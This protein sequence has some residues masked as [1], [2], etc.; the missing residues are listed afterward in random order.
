MPQSGGTLHLAAPYG[1]A[2]K[3]LDPHATYTS[4]DMV[5]SKAFH[6]S[7]YTWESEKNAPALDLARL[8]KISEDGKTFTYELFDNIYFHNGR[9]LTTDDV[10]WS[11]TRIMDPTKGYPGRYKSEHWLARRNMRRVKPRKSAASKIDDRTFSLTFKDLVDP[12]TQ[13]FE[14]IT[15]ILPREEVESGNFLSHPVGLGPF[16]FESHVEGSK[17][18]GKKFDKYFKSGKPYA[19]AVE[20]TISGDNSALDMAFRAGELDA[21]VLSENAYVL[22]KADPELSKGLIE[23]SEVFT[24]HMGMNTDKKPFDDVRVRQ[25]INYAVDR[26]IIIRKLLKDKAYKA[27]G[28]LPATAAAFDKER[29]PYPYDPAK[30]KQLLAQAGYPNG[31]EVTI[32]VTEGT[33]SLGVLEAMMPFLKEVGITATAK[34]VDSNTLVDEMDQGKAMAWFRSAGTGPDSLNALRCFDSRVS[35]SGCNRSAF[36]DPAYD[37]ILDEAAA[38][39]DPAKRVELLKRLTAIFSK[40][41]CL[42]QQLQQG[43]SGNPTMD[44][45]C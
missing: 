19:N 33:S 3:S 43:C 27:T 8:V 11:Y 26:D 4:Q 17:I 40:S 37:A 25:A 16:K 7:L 44:S 6:R 14:A 22:Y 35:R 28:W 13:F 42:V 9:K 31:F 23:L 41:A 30:A 2:L 45:W 10:V 39:A 38:E 15:A 12:G 24:R 34:V 18:S 32:S 36:K 5:V 1:A 21:T 29:A 20:F